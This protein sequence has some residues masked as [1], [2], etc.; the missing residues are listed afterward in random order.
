MRNSKDRPAKKPLNPGLWKNCHKLKIS[1]I[2][3][4]VKNAKSNKASIHAIFQTAKAFNVSDGYVSEVHE[5][6]KSFTTPLRAPK[7]Y[8]RR[9]RKTSYFVLNVN[10]C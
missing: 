9:I 7:R 5:G 2:L 4:F 6:K 3:A 8:A 10:F 1:L